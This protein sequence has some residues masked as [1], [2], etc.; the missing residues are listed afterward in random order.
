MF[1]RARCLAFRVAHL[2]L[3]CLRRVGGCV[4]GGWV[5]AWSADPCELAVASLAEVVAVDAR[6]GAHNLAQDTVLAEAELSGC[7][8]VWVDDC[9]H[10][11]ATL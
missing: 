1:V 6:P 11:V 7:K 2:R 4:G 9:L 5:G 3:D 8:G 10:V